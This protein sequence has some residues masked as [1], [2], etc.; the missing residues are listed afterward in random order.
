MQGGSN[1]GSSI[2]LAGS[3]QPRS[4]SFEQ[5]ARLG[6]QHGSD[7]ATTSTSSSDSNLIRSVNHALNVIGMG[8]SQWLLLGYTSF[9]WAA[10]ASETMILSFLGPSVVCA[11][12]AGPA[13]ESLLT[14]V[15]FAGMLVGV[16]VLGSVSDSHGR[17][18]GFLV[19]ALLLGAAGVASAVAP[20]FGWLVLCR[21]MVGA[22]LGGTPIAVTL[23]AEWVPSARRGILSLLMQSSWTVGTAVQSL[24]AWAI[25]GSLGWR[26]FLFLSAL[27]LFVLVIGYPWLPESPYWLVAKQRYKDAEDIVGKVAEFNKVEA[28]LHTSF[29]PAPRESYANDSTKIVVDDGII[30]SEEESQGASWTQPVVAVLKSVRYALRQV[31]GERLARTTGI[32]WLVWFAN[33][34]TYY[35][36]VLLT[37]SLQVE[38]EKDKGEQ[39]CHD[40][41]AV[42][43]SSD[44]FAVFIT[45]LAEAPGL[46]GAAFLIDYKGRLWCLRIG[47]LICAICIFCL[48]IGGRVLQLVLLFISRAAIEGTFSVLYVYT[49]ELYPTQIRSFGLALCNGFARL[50]GF[51]APFFTVYLVEN[52]KSSWSMI[53]LGCLCSIALIGCLLL[54]IE[55]MGTD[56]QAD[57]TH[58]ARNNNNTHA[59]EDEDEDVPLVVH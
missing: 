59:A 17:R 48:L 10:D 6:T 23:F 28:P 22:G 30:S 19:S 50:G 38:S 55:T 31:F 25:L 49:P 7:S 21:M 3:D 40:G 34:T 14:S 44:Y 13:E 42:F 58:D 51:S 57:H 9:A 39:R 20:S 16:Y 33:A 5:Q 41:E 2:P 43:S 53:L 24:M 12:D 26:W 32:L 29:A 1:E 15:V 35:G 36:L 45:S 52:G 47:M 11:F 54:P 37:T 18:K 27:P 56:L 46:L 8:R 4:L